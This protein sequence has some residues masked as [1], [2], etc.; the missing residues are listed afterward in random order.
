[1]ARSKKGK[2]NK[3]RKLG[4]D[5]KPSTSKSTA[6]SEENIC[7]GSKPSNS[8]S[9]ANSEEK[10]NPNVQ[11]S[12]KVKPEAM[13][14]EN[15]SGDNRSPPKTVKKILKRLAKKNKEKSSNDFEPSTSTTTSEENISPNRQTSKKVKPGAMQEENSSGDE[16]PSPSKVVKKSPKKLAKK[17]IEKS[18]DDSKSSPSKSTANPEKN[19]SPTYRHASKKVKPGAM[20]E[21]NSSSDEGPSPSKAVKK[22]PKM[23]KK[24]IEK[25]S[26]SKSTLNSEEKN[27]PNKQASKKVKPGVIQEENLSGDELSLPSAVKNSP[28]KLVKKSIEKSPDDPKPSTSKSKANSEENISPSKRLSWCPSIPEKNSSA[29][30]APDEPSSPK[31]AYSSSYFSSK[32]IEERKKMENMPKEIE[33]NEY[34]PFCC[35]SIK[36]DTDQEAIFNQFMEKRS[37]TVCF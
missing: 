33:V 16:G 1:M 5:S 19:I 24:S 2:K 27:S 20:Q 15:L 26:T 25:P 31:P 8:K 34:P 10:I 32:A 3:E 28:K 36:P 13:Q 22:S 17:N 9:T 6:N 29:D 23:T 18:P 30:Q 37:S 11:A 35:N 7:H 4:E 21:E 12:K 14:V